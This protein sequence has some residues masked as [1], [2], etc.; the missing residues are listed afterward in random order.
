MKTVLLLDVLQPGQ[1]INS[2]RYIATLA[3]LKA[4]ISKIRTEKKTG[5]FLQHDNARLHASLKTMKK[6]PD[7]GWTVLPRPLCSPNLAPSNSLVFGPMEDGQRGQSFPKYDSNIAAVRK[8]VTSADAHFY[9]RNLQPLVHRCR[10][11][12]ASSGDYAER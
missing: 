7:F 4:L 9:E 11:C 12:T 8:L 6:V 10:K 1:T 5:L 2:D 3:N